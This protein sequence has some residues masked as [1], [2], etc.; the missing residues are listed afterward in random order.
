[1]SRALGRCLALSAVLLLALPLAA[2]ARPIDA[3]WSSSSWGVTF[4]QLVGRLAD[5]VAAAAPKPLW[6]RQGTDIGPDGKP[7]PAPVQGSGPA[8][9]VGPTASL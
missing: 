1:M 6:Q 2:S 7:V 4:E 5:W 3:P 9:S 8:P